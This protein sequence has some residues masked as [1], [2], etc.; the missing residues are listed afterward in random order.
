M[1][2]CA[3]GSEKDYSECCEPYIK[4]KKSPATAEALMRARY[5][6]FVHHEFDYIFKTH[7]DSTRNE[8]D[9]EG[10]RTWGTESKWLGLEIL[11]RDKGLEKDQEGSIEFRCKFILKDAEQSHHELSTF[12]KENGEWFF[13]DGVLKNNTV[14]RT[15]IKIGRND[16]CPCGSGK[17][18]KKCCI[19]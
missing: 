7:H 4:G 11:S 5:S 9:Q 18:Y 1:A 17:K 14:Q 16:P 13:V 15:S 3:C 2:T 10:V 8:L 19:A 6:A 12:K